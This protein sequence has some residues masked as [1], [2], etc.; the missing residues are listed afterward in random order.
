MQEFLNFLQSQASYDKKSGLINSPLN[1]RPSSY[2]FT[3]IEGTP[4][5][6]ALA[7]KKAVRTMFNNVIFTN[8]DFTHFSF[9]KCCFRN[10]TFNHCRIRRTLFHE[11]SVYKTDFD[12]CYISE[13]ILDGHNDWR[14]VDITASAVNCFVFNDNHTKLSSIHFIECALY[15]FIPRYDMVFEHCI[16]KEGCKWEYFHTPFPS[17]GDF[18]AYAPIWAGG[19]DINR[20][21]KI[22]VNT[23]DITDWYDRQFTVSNGT[24]LEELDEDGE[25]ITEAGGE[26]GEL[27]C[28]ITLNEAIEVFEIEDDLPYS[29]VHYRKHS[30]LDP[31]KR[32]WPLYEEKEKMKHEGVFYR[33]EK[34]V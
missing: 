5:D 11:C 10:C 25:P 33:P 24:V 1:E 20:I 19:G 17:E 26:T 16:L 4:D 30:D 32:Y 14:Q 29:D 7:E 12:K 34:S 31:M 8:I 2:A 27:A 3:Y 18:I 22:K 15:S 9:Y 28:F 23:K 21:M 13:L 6:E